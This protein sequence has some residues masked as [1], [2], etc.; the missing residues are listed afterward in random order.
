MNTKKLKELV[1]KLQLQ[2]FTNLLNAHLSKLQ[3]VG[4]IKRQVFHSSSLKVQ[5]AISQASKEKNM[6]KVSKNGI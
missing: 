4:V 6:T 5:R 3:K 2:F 1:K